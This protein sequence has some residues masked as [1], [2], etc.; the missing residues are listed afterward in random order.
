MIVVCEYLI[1]LNL[2]K[3]QRSLTV[4][5]TSD[6]IW[7]VTSP[8]GMGQGR[9]RERRG[10]G[11]LTEETE[12]ARGNLL[13]EKGVKGSNGGLQEVEDTPQGPRR[14]GRLP[15]PH[16]RTDPDPHMRKVRWVRLE[17]Q[18]L[19]PWTPSHPLVR[20]GSSPFQDPLENSVPWK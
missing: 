9:V 8:V 2:L 16:G 19:G 12:A 7:L 6:E 10:G 5:V 15:H 3:H 20:H 17:G 18:S 4:N 11:A 14:E 13:L 1:N